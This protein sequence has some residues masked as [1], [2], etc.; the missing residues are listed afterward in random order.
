MNSIDKILSNVPNKLAP[1]KGRLLLSEPFLQDMFFKRSVVLLADYSEEGSFG[2][3]LNKPI[4]FSFNQIVE[5]FPDFEAPV[6]MGGPV[7]PQSIFFIHTLGD[8][9]KDSQK[10]MPGLYYG[11]SVEDVKTL[12]YEKKIHPE[13]IRFFLGYSGW[14]ENQLE[15]ELERKSWVVTDTT[16]QEIMRQTNESFWKSIVKSLGKEFEIWTKLPSDPKLN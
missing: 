6:Y 13:N 2:L 15:E 1:A 16:P 11:G 5:N 12:M 9:I 14:S 7:S 4:E 3:I 10:I 8:Q